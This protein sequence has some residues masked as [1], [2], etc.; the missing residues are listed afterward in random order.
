MPAVRA[1]KQQRGRE[2]WERILDA[3][4]AVLADLGYDGFTLVEISR[5][6]GL[7]NGA[8]YHRVDSKET[9][10]GAV[11]K[12]FI[13]RI[14]R[15]SLLQTP[16]VAWNDLDLGELVAAAVASLADGARSEGKLLRAFVLLE[17]RDAG[18]AERGAEAVRREGEAFVRLVAPRLA[19]ASHPDPVGAATFGFQMV[20]GS[21]MHRVV[22]PHHVGGRRL[23]WDLYVD[24]LTV[25]TAAC[26]RADSTALPFD[27]GHRVESSA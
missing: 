4:E 5:R 19:G 16:P 22:W 25:A 27:G 20:M 10:L 14:S 3:G 17:G 26:L 8:I 18:C 2:S 9:L 24:R 23:G 6:A 1:P 12:R 15:R 7:S 13:D 21:L 11:H